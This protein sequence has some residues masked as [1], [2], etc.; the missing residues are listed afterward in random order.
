MAGTGL[1]ETIPSVPG[2][3]EQ[4]MRTSTT[5]GTAT[6]YAI[7][8][9]ALVAVAAAAGG[10]YAGPPSTG[11]GQPL[12][13]TLET[14]SSPGRPASNL[15]DAFAARVKALSHGRMMVKVV[16]GESPS[17][18]TTW[19][20]LRTHL[21]NVRTNKVQLATVWGAS[22]ELAGVKTVRALYAPFQLTSKAAASRATRGPIAAKILDGFNG[23]GLTGLTLAPQGL[24]RI[25]AA[26]KPLEALAAFRGASIRTP[27]GPTSVAVL[28]ALGSRP[29]DRSGGT[30]TE[31]LANGTIA[32]NEI[33]WEIGSAYLPTS[34]T[35]GNLV[36]YPLVDVLVANAAA[37]KN[38]SPAQQALLRNAAAAA[39]AEMLTGWN[40]RAAAKA[41]CKAGGSI[42]TATRSELEGLKTKAGAVTARFSEDAATAS[43][44]RSIR[45][46][47]QTAG[48]TVATCKGSSTLPTPPKPP[49]G[50]P[51]TT[52][53]PPSGAY[54]RTLTADAMRAGGADENAIFHNQGT[55]TYDI[56][57][58]TGTESLKNGQYSFRCSFALSVVRNLVKM[59]WD[60]TSDCAG[61][62]FYF[63]WKLDGSD[64]IIDFK[65][66][67][68]Q[69]VTDPDP[70]VYSGRWARAA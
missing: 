63:T 13:L 55:H 46:L 53:L 6:C 5:L 69:P 43:I 49:S 34:K 45:A 14:P 24:S 30:F 19:P 28:K 27:Y 32:A 59:T 44:L 18:T 60:P 29:V 70:G 67:N 17:A 64:L 8:I 58:T 31:A 52:T 26:K 50:V 11:A 22:M 51:A 47:H 37:F 38:L 35:A 12:A 41:F 62:P 25:Y 3:K 42:T 48:D 40:E 65:N 23:S 2:K 16:Y 33:N 10:A 57:G 68:G 1:P 7:I 66:A 39:R 54:R 4:L 56:Q 61:A 36:L 20:W 21:N 9:A 15:A